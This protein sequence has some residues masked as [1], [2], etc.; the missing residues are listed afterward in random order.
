MGK[1]Y[2]GVGYLTGQRLSFHSDLPANAVRWT[3][4]RE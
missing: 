3:T 1:N 2:R 4:I